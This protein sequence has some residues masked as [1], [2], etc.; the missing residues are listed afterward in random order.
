M[1]RAMSAE[2]YLERADELLATLALRLRT[3]GQAEAPLHAHRFGRLRARRD[4]AAALVARNGV[5]EEA[6]VFLLELLAEIRRFVPDILPEGA[7]DIAQ[8]YLVIGR[9]YLVDGREL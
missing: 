7:A 8:D 3:D 6:R 1:E 9:A 5:A 4:A 2:G